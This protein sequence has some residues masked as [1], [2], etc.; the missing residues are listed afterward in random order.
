MSLSRCKYFNTGDVLQ[1]YVVSPSCSWLLH[2]ISLLVYPGITMFPRE[3]RQKGILSPDY[4][5]NQVSRYTS[6]DAQSRIKGNL[7]GFV[8]PTCRLRQLS[9]GKAISKSRSKSKTRLTKRGREMV[10]LSAQFPVCLFHGKDF[11]FMPKM[12]FLTWD[13]LND[14]SMWFALF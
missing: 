8:F 2:V 11:N 4:K 10:T 12:N 6:S 9:S 14:L 7:P 1:S 13:Q 3:G 5:K